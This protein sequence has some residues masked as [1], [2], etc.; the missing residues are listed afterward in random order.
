[1][2]QGPE[3]D[4]DMRHCQFLNL[5]GDM[6]INERQ[7]HA[8]LPFLKINGRHGDPPIKGPIRGL[9][10]VMVQETVRRIEGA[11]TKYHNISLYPS[12]TLPNST[13][14]LICTINMIIALQCMYVL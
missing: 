9:V 11:K 8:T 13:Y 12:R 10:P 3:I 2:R 14:S 1:M 5:T 4:S 6:G 7:R